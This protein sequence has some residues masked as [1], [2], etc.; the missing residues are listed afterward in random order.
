MRKATVL[1][2]ALSSSLL[3][4]AF[5]GFTS[6]AVAPAHAADLPRSADLTY[7]VRWG[8]ISLEAEQH[9][10]LD[11]DRYTLSTEL[12]LPLGFAN[13]RYVSQGRV[14]PQGL[15]PSSY[16]DY[17]VGDP[18][19]RSVAKVDRASHVV[20]YGRTAV[21]LHEKPLAE[22]LQDINAL[23][24]Q[25]IWLGDKVAGQ[26][27]PVTNGRNVV[28]HQFSRLPE[29]TASYDG[30]RY[31][32]LRLVST[33]PEGGFEVG[34]AQGLGWMPLKIVRVQDGKTLT[35]TATQVRY[36]P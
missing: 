35:F 4:C 30:K 33:S 32:T 22:G 6:L 5:A 26:T 7:Q 20:S 1:R 19:P 29:G 13:R 11:G 2:T 21:P 31:P 23:A 9:W 8:L 25:L 15:E 36:T 34:L 12:K 16:E 3:S 27:V 10:R 17:E 28:P 18:K 14:G 24:Y